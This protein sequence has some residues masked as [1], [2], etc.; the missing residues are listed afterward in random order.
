MSDATVQ[1]EER[2]R[3][4]AL[5]VLWA[6]P[7]LW[8]VNLVVAR[9][10]PGLVEPYTLALGRWAIAAAV[11]LALSWAELSAKRAVVLRQW[12]Q[13]LVLGACGML[14][15]G[16][17]VYEGA[18]TTSAMNIALIYAASPV[19]IALGAVRWLG[20]RL[21]AS[22]VLGVVLALGG[23]VHVVVQ[24][25]WDA[26]AQVQLVAGDAWIAAAMV[27]WAAY[28]LLQRLWP[29]ALG[30]T[31]R[32]AAISV[33][34]VLALLPGAVWE[35]RHGP[36]PEPLWPVLGVMALAAIVPGVG[37]YWLY[38]WAQKV[39]GASRVAVT[40]YLG[41]LYSALAAYFVLGE[42]LG[43][44]HLGGALLVLPGVYLVS[45]RV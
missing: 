42:P 28:A 13:H 6:V 45:R 5:L 22:Q 4:W 35:W 32:L 36:W 26:L 12:W 43:W 23:V 30:D 9:K 3:R 15:C 1:R 29:T 27:S 11:L 41:P 39:L 18:Q 34:G 10:A 25:R 20:E 33:G 7:I 8:T 24:G 44:H 38:A 31:A 14:V 16:A 17:W 19:L 40:L 2:Q 21:R 37:A